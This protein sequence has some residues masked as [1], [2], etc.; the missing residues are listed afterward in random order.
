V[1]SLTAK[2]YHRPVMTQEVLDVFDLAPGG[3]YLDATLGGGG[4]TE[5]L[6]SHR[7]DLYAVAVD[8]DEEAIEA[9]TK[10]LKRFG[11]R[12][13]IVH[14]DVASYV[15][16]VLRDSKAA[17]R[18]VGVIADLGVSSRHFNEEERGFSL[19]GHA[20]LDMRMD[21]SQSLSA[22]EVVNQY[23]QEELV[24]I[25]RRYGDV[26]FAGRVARTIVENRPISYS[27]ELAEL[28]RKAIPKKAVSFHIHPATTVFQ[29]IRIEVNQ[30]FKQLQELLESCKSLVVPGGVVVVISYHSGEDRLVKLFM[31]EA[32][33]DR[34]SC[35][36]QL[37]CVCGKTRWAKALTRRPIVA[38]EDEVSSNPRARSA[39]LRA[40]QRLH[41]EEV[42]GI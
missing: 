34:C 32:T 14:S 4:H 3:T 10:R 7:D 27:D 9:A 23:S 11:G 13:E 5:A 1:R 26:A 40:I 28:V 33:T 17:R 6:L 20:I 8:R 16:S 2:E 25:F 12:V 31:R 35:P 21:R 38:T 36:P 30:E 18:F 15:H 29:A 22:Y 19:T 41:Q 42:R 24:A 39:K 37:P